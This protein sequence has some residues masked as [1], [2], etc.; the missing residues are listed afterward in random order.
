ML[1]VA[2]TPWTTTVT[3]RMKETTSC[4]YDPHGKYFACAQNPKGIPSA[5]TRFPAV[6]DGT[7][8]QCAACSL[9]TCP[10]PTTSTTEII[11]GK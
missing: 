1:K 11:K 6:A 9:W 7:L 10:D 3:P 5:T 8:T 2:N 4:G